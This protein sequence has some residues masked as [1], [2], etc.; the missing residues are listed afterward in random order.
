GGYQFTGVAPGQY[1]LL[2]SAP[3]STSVLST[4]TVGASSILLNPSLTSSTTTVT[5]MVTSSMGPLSGATVIIED[6]QGMIWATTTTAGDGTYT[7]SGLHAGAYTVIA[8]A[9]GYQTSNPVP[10][11][12]DAG[13]IV[14]STNLTESALAITDASGPIGLSD[15]VYVPNWK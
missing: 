8:T 4:I 5:G 9:N 13:Q 1:Q 12:I 10:I 14:D 3:G 2:V 11:Q 6:S 15:T 7:V